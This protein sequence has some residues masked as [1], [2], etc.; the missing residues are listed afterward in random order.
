MK[1]FLGTELSYFRISRVNSLTFNL[2]DVTL[3][4]FH[5][6]GPYHIDTSPLI[7]SANQYT[8]FYYDW[9]LRHERNNMKYVFSTFLL[10]YFVL[11]ILRILI[12]TQRKTA[13]LQI[14]FSL[15]SFQVF[16]SGLRNS[17]SQEKFW[18]FEDRQRHT[19]YI[20][21]KLRGKSTL[22][23]QLKEDVNAWEHFFLLIPSNFCTGGQVLQSCNMFN[24]VSYFILQNSVLIFPKQWTFN[25]FFVLQSHEFCEDSRQLNL[26]PVVSLTSN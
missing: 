7:R 23:M 1:H 10:P 15:G 19:L 3:W 2:Y 25:F 12:Q 11:Y 8:G 18:S 6:G 14:P 13:R 20:Q 9:D 4:L 21:W 22:P 16:W 24:Q 26:S 5:D 17:C